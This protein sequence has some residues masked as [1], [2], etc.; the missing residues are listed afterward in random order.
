MLKKWSGFLIGAVCSGLACWL[1]LDPTLSPS[2]RSVTVILFLC[3]TH[4][5]Y[6]YNLIYRISLTSRRAVAA[7]VAW[8]VILFLFFVAVSPGSGLERWRF[9]GAHGLHRQLLFGLFL[10]VTGAFFHLP[11]AFGVLVAVLIAY[12]V[13]PFFAEAALALMIVFYLVIM[14]EVKRARLTRSYVVLG[15]FVLGFILMAAVLFPLIHLATQRSPQDLDT[16]MRGTPQGIQAAGA[17]ADQADRMA[18]DTRD[19]IWT[20]LQTAT[21]STLVVLLLGV[22]LAYFLVRSDFRGRAILDAMVNLPIVLPPPVAGLALVFILGPE[23]GI[24][25]LL[26]EKFGLQ[27][28]NDWKGIV[29]AQVFVSSPF[30]IRS[31]QS[32]FQAVDPRLEDCLTNARGDSAADALAGDAAAGGSRHLHGLHPDVG[33]GRSA[34]SARCRSSPSIPRRCRSGFTPSLSPRA[35][36]GR[37]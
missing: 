2:P 21:V 9:G 23:P 12:F 5:F 7:Y 15:G 13:V 25:S 17:E 8:Y 29:L 16:L 26:R 36:R 1:W 34:S 18:K 14:V 30:L 35:R 4:V 10:L 22:P 37:A 27:F 31:A 6:L 24:G 28:A 19:A 33:E 11:A 3:A 20:S 32:A